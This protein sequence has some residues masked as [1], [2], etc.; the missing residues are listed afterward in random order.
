[1]T[2]AAGTRPGTARPERVGSLHD[3]QVPIAL[4]LHSHIACGSD[5]SI[6]HVERFTLVERISVQRHRIV[7]HQR[8]V[9]G[10]TKVSAAPISPPVEFWCFEACVLA[11][12]AMA[13][14]E[15]KIER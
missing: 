8:R 10:D 14:E 5:Q 11:F 13:D 7:G 15:N 4:Q 3:D 1:M 12:L 6:A 2:R 9:L